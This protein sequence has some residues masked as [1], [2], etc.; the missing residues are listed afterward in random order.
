MDEPNLPLAGISFILWMAAQL[1]AVLQYRRAIDML[2]AAGYPFSRVG[3]Y[4]AKGWRIRKAYAEAFPGGQLIRRHDIALAVGI[5]FLVLTAY[6]IG[7][8]G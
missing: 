1:T 8:F 3:I 5:A 4:P 6:A 7:I 2:R